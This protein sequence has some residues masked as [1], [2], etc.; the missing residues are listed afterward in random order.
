M[1]T[2]AGT[3]RL[4][5]FWPA[6]R[7]PSRRCPP[8]P[9]PRTARSIPSRPRRGP[10][11]HRQHGP[12]GRRNVR[13]GRSVVRHR[14]QPADQLRVDEMRDRREQRVDDRVKR[15]SPPACR[16]YRRSRPR[17]RPAAHSPPDPG[18]VVPRS[19]PA[20]EAARRPTSA[21]PTRPRR[22]RP[23]PAANDRTAKRTPD[24]DAN[25]TADRLR[26]RTRRASRSA[27]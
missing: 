18:S 16:P 24:G 13:T 25:P 21:A 5:P 11:R 15:L 9:P 22:S 4:P 27:R 3:A 8:A 1:A 20:P 6:R 7:A 10:P 17:P 14:H 26:W 2:P 12:L 19:K 23:P